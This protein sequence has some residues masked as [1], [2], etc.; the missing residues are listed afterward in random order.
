VSQTLDKEM[1]ANK[2]TSMSRNIEGKV[3]V[4]TGASSGPGESTARH[5]AS[6]GAMIVL[7][8]RRQDRLDLIAKDI[9][10]DG[11]KAL[12]VTVVVGQFHQ[13]SVLVAA[14]VICTDHSPGPRPKRALPSNSKIYPV[15]CGSF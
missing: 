1:T 15:Q 5:L 14:P 9:Q 2:E 4:I 8:A 10:A 7:G 3:V 13:S 12:A 11:G 6:L